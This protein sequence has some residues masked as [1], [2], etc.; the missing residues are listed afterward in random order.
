[1]TTN[2]ATGPNQ[3]SRKQTVPP[4]CTSASKGMVADTN[5]PVIVADPAPAE[6]HPVYGR[7]PMGRDGFVLEGQLVQMLDHWHQKAT[8]YIDALAPDSDDAWLPTVRVVQGQLFA[9]A[10]DYKPRRGG[11]AAHQFAIIAREMKAEGTIQIL[12]VE[13]FHKL[14]DGL[15]SATAPLRP[16]KMPGPSTRGRKLTRSGLLQRYQSF[17]IQELETISWHLYG[18]RDF[19][20]FYK[21]KDHAVTIRCSSHFVDGKFK[22]KRKSYPFFDESKLS[23]RARSVLKSLKIETVIHDDRPRLPKSRRISYDDA[24]KKV[25]AR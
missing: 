4:P 20:K 19:A 25:G 9:A 23:T 18:A 3:S 5:P 16:A 7:I 10:L 1:M 12:D 13:A 14:V 22:A 6:P 21:Q 17:L 2:T 24:C 8:N 15:R 11:D